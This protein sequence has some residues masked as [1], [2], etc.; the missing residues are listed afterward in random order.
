MNRID[1]CYYIPVKYNNTKGINNPVFTIFTYKNKF[2]EK[3]AN[4]SKISLTKTIIRGVI[5]YV[6]KT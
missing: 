3:I 5:C 1:P 6:T 2:K 4:V